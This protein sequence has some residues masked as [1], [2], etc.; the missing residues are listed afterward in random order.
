MKRFRVAIVGLGTLGS[1]CAVL[2]REDGRIEV[3]GVVR[4]EATCNAHRPP[5]LRE[6]RTVTDVRDLGVIDAALVCVPTSEAVRVAR[7]LIER[8]IPVVE[9]AA[10]R[11]REFEAHVEGLRTLA[12]RHRVPVVAG[13]GWNP[14]AL[15]LVEGLFAV[16]IPK[17]D[18]HADDTAGVHL[19]HTLFEQ[20]V[21]GVKRAMATEVRT[22][23]G[24]LQR[25]LYVEP[26]RGAELAAIERAIRSDPASLGVETLVF[27]LDEEGAMREETRGVLLRRHGSVGGRPQ[28]LLLE[29]RVGEATLAAR[30]MLAAALALPR[31]ERRGYALSELP[32]GALSAYRPI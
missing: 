21:S 6:L 24:A 20:T 13:A 25:Y 16:L 11:A 5:Q 9:C 30:I 32:I 12:R 28:F 2:A 7:E 14:G 29:A 23:E 22:P 27:P 17:G 8:Q 4:R 31:L 10:L 19:H 1:A 15:S 3:A 26:E 18:T